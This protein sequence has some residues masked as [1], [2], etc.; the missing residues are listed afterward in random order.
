MEVVSTPKI[1]DYAFLSDRHTGALVAHGSIDWLCLPRF[2]SPAVLTRL[3]GT[4]EH[5]YWRIA[6][7]DAHETR[8]AY[9]GRSFVLDTWWDTPDGQVM[10][11][12]W[13]AQ[14]ESATSPEVRLVRSVTCKEGTADIDHDLVLRFD[15]GQ[16]TPWVRKVTDP[17]GQSVILAMAGPDAVTLHGPALDGE[18]RAHRRR[19]HLEA[20]QTLTWTLTW[21]PSYAPI[22]RAIDTDEALARLVADWEQWHE[23]VGTHGAYSDAVDRSLD[24]LRALTVHR[25][26]GIVAAPTTSLPE[27]L[28]GGRNW[29]YR[30]TWLR[31]SAF[32]IDALAR[33]GHL[34]VA[35]HWRDW[36]LRAIAGDSQDLQI[37]Y[38][39]D[40]TRTL[41]ERTLDH[42]P[43]YRG[44]TPVRV[45]N[46]AY[47]QYQADVVGEVM[48]A[49][50]Q[51]REAGVA[52]DDFSWSLQCNLMSLLES[53]LDELDHG[54]WEVRGEPHRFTH[55][56]VMMWAALDR[57]VRAVETQ[58]LKGPV[59]RWT[60]HRDA[61]RDEILHRGVHDGGFVQHYDTDAVDAALLQIPQTGFI[62]PDDPIMLR[63]VERIEHDLVD[64]HGFVQRYP[65]DG[66]DGLSGSEGSFL[67]C[68]FWLVEQ[69]ARSGRRDDAITLMERLLAIRS[70]LGLLSEEYDPTTQTMLGNYPQAFSHLALIRAADALS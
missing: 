67:M 65:T 57:A 42:L 59:H 49:L 51:L 33:H 28:G 21:H 19:F 6:P 35:G 7:V 55:G 4:D 5:G 38:G 24:V 52:E 26:G 58:G 10:T 70:D 20:G 47:T 61:L 2:D 13:F 32:T 48:L 16:A 37:M 64:D 54:I 29:D 69:Y 17:D 8:R 50:D 44:S 30:Y 60:G 63:T 68:T 25:T 31:D 14:N 27:S 43:G 39:V 23:S 3:L 66:T 40:G 36:L 12:D 46:D 53:R 15:Y 18:D 45:G 56:R 22:P 1:S 62:A 34:H 11:T 9:R 41:T